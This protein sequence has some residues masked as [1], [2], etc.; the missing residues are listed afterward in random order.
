MILIEMQGPCGS[1]VIREVGP[2]DLLRRA[3]RE[4]YQAGDPIPVSVDEAAA[5]LREYS[6]R[7][8]AFYSCE[9]A[10]RWADQYHGPQS[11]TIRRAIRHF[12]TANAAKSANLF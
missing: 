10:D 5:Y 7:F 1:P 4:A 9:S 11:D 8:W 6:P 12:M 2:P 3:V